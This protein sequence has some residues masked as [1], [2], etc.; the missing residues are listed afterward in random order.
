VPKLKEI[1]WIIIPDR[2]TALTQLQAKALDMWF[3]VPGSYLARVQAIKPYRALRVP[4]YIFNHLDFNLTHAALKDVAV[5]RALRL[6]A[7]RGEII[8]KI[9]HGVGYLKEQPAA[10]TAPY[11]DPKLHPVP[12]DIAKANALLDAAGWK[13]GQDGIR[14]KSGVKLNLDFVSTTGSPDVD[15]QI[16]LIRAS[17]SQI[18]VALNVRRYPI[19]LLLAPLQDGGIIYSGKFD[20]VGFAWALDP[21][22]DL[23]STY[24]CANI[25]PNGQNDPHWCNKRAN[26]AMLA[27][28]AHYDQAQRDADDAI[29]QEEMDNDVPIIVMSG[30]ED[31][32]AINR[33]LKDFRP[34]A[35]SPFDNM[36]NVDI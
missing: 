25:P 20:V 3:P 1:D 8:R 30:R 33:D 31:I 16:E 11:W 15:Q 32:W 27:L 28:Y 36:M 14:T 4:S 26:D 35:V 12:Y 7:P 18:G 21:I 29:V 17:W 5:R 19:N 24:G 2:N 23:S 34:N 22:G 13:R 9:G 10:K 6:A